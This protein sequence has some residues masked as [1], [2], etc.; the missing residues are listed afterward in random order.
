M[1]GSLALSGQKEGGGRV[2]EFRF[3]SQMGPLL[4]EGLWANTSPLC[5]SVT[6]SVK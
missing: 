3:K 4:A 6:S 1:G 5:G 2:E